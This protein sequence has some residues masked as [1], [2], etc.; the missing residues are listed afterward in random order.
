MYR[1][2]KIICTIGPNTCEPKNLLDLAIGGMNIA[3]LNMSHGSHQWH[4]EAISRIKE[5]NKKDNFNIGIM[6]DTKGPEIRT[7]DL[8][9]PLEVTIGD[10]I[11]LTIDRKLEKEVNTIEVNYD[12]FIEDVEVDDLVLIDSGIITLKVVSKT[13]TTVSLAVL[14]DG[15]ITSRRHLNIKSKSANLPAITD[16]DW[17]DIDF[18]ITQEADFIAL[19]FTNNGQVV[20]EL[21]KYLQQNKSEIKVVSKVESTDAVKNLE[22][23]IDHS[24][25]IMVARGDLGAELPI[26]DVPI[27]QKQIVKLCRKAGKPVIVATQLLESMMHNPTPTRA[28]VTDVFCAVNQRADAIMMSGETA[29]GKYPLKALAVMSKVAYRAEQTFKEDKRILVDNSEEPKNEICLGA[30]IIANNIEAKAIIVF[31]KK[32]ITAS[33]VAQCRPNCP[34]FAFTDSNEVKKQLS[35]YWGITAFEIQLGEPESTITQTIELLKNKNILKVGES[36]VLVSDIIVSEELVDTVQVREV[37]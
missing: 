1:H 6:I 24:D 26:E 34:I 16:K 35:L 5:L 25:G 31:T 2:T 3:R 14:D 23:I 21:K 17:L 4:A 19:S 29:N 12:G 20:S 36:V 8:K 30:S 28:E 15:V 13:K 10:Q 37:K 33:L 18:A 22:S 9:Q 32:G 27:I 7:G 11:I